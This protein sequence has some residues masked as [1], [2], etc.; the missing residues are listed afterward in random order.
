MR[1]LIDHLRYYF[2]SIASAI[3][4]LLFK[5]LT[6]FSFLMIAFYF[7]YI[8]YYSTLCYS[9]SRVV[10]GCLALCIMIHLNKSLG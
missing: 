8:V 5:A 9:S 1:R 3:Q 2:G 6:M 10:T 4:S 7:G